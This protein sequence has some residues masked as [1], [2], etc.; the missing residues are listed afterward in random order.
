MVNTGSHKGL[1]KAYSKEIYQ[2]IK[3]DWKK[4]GS[5]PEGLAYG[6]SLPWQGGC[7]FWGG[8]KRW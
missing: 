3:N 7:S 4:V 1:D 6:V 5:L 8:E 2:L